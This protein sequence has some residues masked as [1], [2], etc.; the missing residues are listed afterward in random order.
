MES[1]VVLISITLVA[2]D[3]EHL[4]NVSQ[5][6]EFPHLEFCLDLYPILK[7]VLFVFFLYSLVSCL[8]NLD[9]IPLSYM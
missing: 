2:K 6:F 1:Q 3:S 4:K 5:P 7:T 8:Y 9:I